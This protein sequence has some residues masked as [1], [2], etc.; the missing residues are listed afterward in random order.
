MSPHVWRCKEN[1]HVSAQVPMCLFIFAPVCLSHPHLGLYVTLIESVVKEITIQVYVSNHI[2]PCVHT[3][4]IHQPVLRFHN[5]VPL[6]ES[7]SISN[8]PTVCYTLVSYFDIS[9]PWTWNDGQTSVSPL[10]YQ[11]DL[12]VCCCVIS[13]DFPQRVNQSSLNPLLHVSFYSSS[14][15]RCFTF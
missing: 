8:S 13:F 15:Q 3:L 9:V 10:N 12:D 4:C 5:E 6:Y 7:C 2:C 1:R 14:R 11:S